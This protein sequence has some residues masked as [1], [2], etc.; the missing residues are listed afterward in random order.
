[1]KKL[2]LLAGGAGIVFV[3]GGG[4]GAFAWRAHTRSPAYSLKQVSAAVDH[5][6]RY[7]FEKYVDVDGLLQAFLSDAA[8]GNP[9]AGAVG[10]AAIGS[11]KP[12]IIK[13]VEEG[14]IPTES[15]IGKGIAKLRAAP[16]PPAIVQDGRNAYFNIDIATQGGAPFALKMHMTQVGDGHWRV[17]RVT[18]WKELRAAEAEEEKARKAA[19]AKANDEKLAKLHV[20]ARLHT[21]VH[22]SWEWEKKNRFQVRF[23][24][25]SEKTITGMTGHIRFPAQGF[26]KGISADLKIAPGAAETAVWENDVNR[27][28]TETVRVYALGETDAFIVD[29]DSLTMSDGTKVRRGD[30]D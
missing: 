17:D 1:M 3:L 23:E 26:D 15:Q 20:V 14:T 7:E 28:M 22:G 16:A 24:N 27:F 13:A 4:G 8:D 11:L 25:K 10:T 9:L 5:R 2:L 18:N 29:V 21:S 30:E 6:D 12:Q 19:I